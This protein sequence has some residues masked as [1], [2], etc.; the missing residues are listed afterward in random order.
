[1]LFDCKSHSL[2]DFLLEKEANGEEQPVFSPKLAIY[3]SEIGIKAVESLFPTLA[4]SCSH[5]V[6]LAISEAL[7]L[8]SG[9]VYLRAIEI[10]RVHNVLEKLLMVQ[11]GGD[12]TVSIVSLSGLVSFQK[13]A[14]GYSLTRAFPGLLSLEW[15]STSQIVSCAHS[16]SLGLRSLTQDDIVAVV[17]TI[18]NMISSERLAGSSRPSSLRRSEDGAQSDLFAKCIN[19]VVEMA[20]YMEDDSVTVLVVT[21]LVQKFNQVSPQVDTAILSGLADACTMIPQRELLSYIRLMNDACSQA[22]KTGNQMLVDAVNDARLRMARNLSSGSSTETYRLYLHELLRAVISQGGDPDPHHHRSNTEI[23][24]V[25]RYIS[26]F[27]ESLAELCQAPHVIKLSE[28]MDSINLF[29]DFWVNLVVHGY[30]ETSELGQQNRAHLLKVAE[31]TP[32]LASEKAWNRTETSLEMNAVLRRGSSNRNIK[33]QKEYLLEWCDLDSRAS[34]EIQANSHKVIFLATSLFV[35]RLRVESVGV[36]SRGLLYLSDPSVHVTGIEKGIAAV[37]MSVVK[38]FVNLQTSFSSKQISRELTE[39]L[40]LCCHREPSLQGCAFKCCD[41]LVSAIPTSLCHESSLFTLLN[42]LSILYDTVADSESNQYSPCTEFSC[43]GVSVVLTDS[44]DWRQYSLGAMHKFAKS[45]ISRV[46]QVADLDVK[47]LL[48]SYVSRFSVHEMKQVDFGVSVALQMAGTNKFSNWSVTDF[49]PQFPVFGIHNGMVSE[50]SGDGVFAELQECAN[51]L[52]TPSTCDGT[53]VR[54]MVSIPFETLSSE[55]IQ[56]G[57]DVW[58]Y[59]MKKRPDL[60]TFLLSEILSFWKRS[61]ESGEGLFSSKF[62]IPEAEYCKMEYSPSDRDEVV[63]N[64]HAASRGMKPH[65]LLIRFFSSHFQSSLQRSTHVLRLFT[66]AICVSLARLRYASF[67]PFA[68]LARF[69][70]VKLGLDVVNA[71]RMFKHSSVSEVS[72]AVFLAAL[73]WFKSR[74]AF[75]YGGNRLKT[76]FDCLVLHQVAQEVGRMKFEPSSV[77]QKNKNLLLAFMD[78]EIART[79]AWLTPLNPKDTTGEYCKEHISGLHLQN[80][81]NLNPLLAINLA[82]RYSKLF[83]G[84]RSLLLKDPLPALEFPSAVPFLVPASGASVPW[85]IVLW[86]CA[87]PA[88]SIN[89]FLPPYNTNAHVIQY[90]MR[91]LES[92]DVNLTFFYVPQIVQAIR[93]DNQMGYV[94]RFIL[95]TAQVSQLF[96]HQIIWNMKA[97]MYRDEEATQADP[98]KP[99]LDRVL[100][101]MTK[102]FENE[103][104]QFYKQEF[105]FFNEVTDISGKLRPYIKK[106]KAEKKVKIDEEMAKIELLPDVYLPSNPDGVIVDI[107]RK[108]GKPLQSHAKAPFMATF[109]IRKQIHTFSDDNQVTGSKDIEKWQSAIFKV[110]DDCR[111]DLLALQ[112]ISV[113]RAIWANAGL[114]VYVFPYRVTATSP[115]CGV[116]DVLPNS[117]SRDMLGR[118]A[119]NGLLEYFV[120]KFGPE[121]SVEFQTARSNFVKSLAGYSVISFL[122][123]FKDRHNGNIMYDDQGHILHIDFGFCFDIVPG[124]VKFEQSPFKLTREMVN[125]MGGGPD[126]QAYRWFEE[127]C[128]KAFLAARP[129]MDTIIQCVVPMLGT[130]LPCFKPATMKKLKNRFVIEKSEKDAAVYMRQLIRKSYESLATIGYDE[131]QRLTNGIPY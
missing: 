61:M 4:E 101:K 57:I 69:E 30:S 107:N 12:E 87:S 5:K 127:L 7:E 58:L 88:I 62:D 6:E 2:S 90:I 65:L 77:L 46:L 70:L 25:G 14:V 116:I 64:G 108:S 47:S 53:F 18:T 26:V 9:G 8:T 105:K 73:S 126:T 92:Q 102:S 15:I 80:A 68:R 97:N 55:S 89:L 63:R 42:L 3:I 109:R 94:E 33:H 85:Q 35:E 52:S 34:F 28:E 19:S 117:I 37:A 99:K 41:F 110:G 16:L 22:F 51:Q 83:D 13:K 125:V 103:D 124:G 121:T 113:F 48:Q 60:A 17:Y 54:Q 96:A 112:L 98:I 31:G 78:H 129:H 49:L 120:S 79:K 86:E 111:Q 11:T 123:Q 114:E 72:H 29:R 82:I 24:Q 128:V 56:I 115:G 91:S 95:E 50:G 106:S 45:W 59:A 104:L 1:M 81:W 67:H 75:P 40:V 10:N 27:L 36:C 76:Q 84:L 39:M 119:V 44:Y 38:H 66:S 21:I 74:P 32:A 20:R 122:L 100:D 130:Q 43:R 23:S 131:F 71:N 118:E 93:H